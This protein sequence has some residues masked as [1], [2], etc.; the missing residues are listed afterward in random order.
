M[1]LM[2]VSGMKG[3]L[4]EAMERSTR[5]SAVELH[6]EIYAVVK[7]NTPVY[8]T[9][10]VSMETSGRGEYRRLSFNVHC[11]RKNVLLGRV[12]MNQERRAFSC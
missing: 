12:I 3:L 9:C 4:D 1:L 8:K 7:F 5:R 6:E 11:S 2:I 10:R